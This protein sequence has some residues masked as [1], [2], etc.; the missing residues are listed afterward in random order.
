[1]NK[2]IELEIGRTGATLFGLYNGLT[3]YANHEINTKDKDSVFSGV[4][5]KLIA[6]AE[7]VMLELV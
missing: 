5:S 6:K 3:H 1:M 2:S 7:K 4:G